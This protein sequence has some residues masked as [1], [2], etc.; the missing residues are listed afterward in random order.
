[1]Q[2][3]SEIIDKFGDRL[4][5]ERSKDEVR[6]ELLS[7]IQTRRHLINESPR[8]EWGI[9]ELCKDIYELAELDRVDLNGSTF[10]EKLNFIRSIIPFA[11]IEPL[12]EGVT[13]YNDSRI[14]EDW[15]MNFLKEGTKYDDGAAVL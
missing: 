12:V 4:V 6:E 13:E 14:G 2:H 9:Y 1:M 10:I 5:L 7:R 15:K 8:N 11:E 3:I